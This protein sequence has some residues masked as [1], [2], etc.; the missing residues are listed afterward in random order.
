MSAIPT[1]RSGVHAYFDKA[2]KGYVDESLLHNMD[3]AK[4]ELVP[5]E[6]MGLSSYKG[7]APT[8]QILVQGSYVFSDVP[9]HLLFARAARPKKPLGLNVLVYNNSPDD[10]I[11]LSC[12]PHLARGACQV[13]LVKMAAKNDAQKWMSGTY[14]ATIDWHRDNLNAHL[15]ALENGQ[16]ALQP[17]HKISFNDGP[18]ALPP[19]RKL[20]TDWIVK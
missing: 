19:Y 12:N 4:T 1:H 7:T 11:D 15:I 10:H 3:P 16:F 9:L 6:I 17:Q 20:K 13:F 5:C 14:L 8:A 18:R 2:I